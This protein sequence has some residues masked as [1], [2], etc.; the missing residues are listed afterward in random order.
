MKGDEKETREIKGEFLRIRYSTE[1]GS[2]WDKIP[3]FKSI[4]KCQ[5]KQ[6]LMAS[7]ISSKI[8]T[9]SMSTRAK[10]SQPHQKIITKPKIEAKKANTKPSNITKIVEGKKAD[11]KLMNFF[12][13][14]VENEDG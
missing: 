7:L 11:K 8:Q 13:F 14:V 4:Q 5:N 12:E 1:F 6:H 2:N 10:Q 9:S 3:R